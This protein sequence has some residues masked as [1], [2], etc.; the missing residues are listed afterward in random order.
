MA[1]KLFLSFLF[2]INITNILY[3]MGKKNQTSLSNIKKIELIDK[4]YRTIAVLPFANSIKSDD[5]AYIGR[6]IQKFLSSYLYSMDTI[7]I[8]TNDF[9][10]PEKYKTN[11]SI[12]YS[13]GSNFNRKAI[14]LNPDTVYKKYLKSKDPEDLSTF[15]REI[16]ADYI[17]SGSYRPHKKSPNHFSVF[18]SIFNTAQNKQVFNKNRIFNHAKL[19]ES[20]LRISIDIKKYFIPF[21]TGYMRIIT[22]ISNY[23]LFINHH[24]V[25]NK[26]TL[27]NLNTGEHAIEFRP[28]D[29]YPFKTNI[30][31]IS[32]QTNE[33]VLNT[34]KYFKKDAFL[35]VNSIPT[36]ASVFLNV[37]NIGYTPLLYT[38]LEKGKYRLKI[39][40]SNYTTLFKNIELNKGT[41]KFF[42][43]L[44]KRKPKQ[45]YKNR[46][47]KN[48][49]I[50]YSALGGGALCLLN[51]YFF[52]SA[53]KL[54]EDKFNYFYFIKYDY[55]K[56]KKH[57]EKEL[58]YRNISY[59]S[60][61]VGLGAMVISFVYFIKVINYDD[62][63][64]GYNFK[65]RINNDAS[66]DNK[67]LFYCQ[68]KF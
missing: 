28:L 66:T 63:N 15:S 54:E 40:K 47:K 41:N 33:L 10:I 29:Y 12:M 44:K 24:L 1:M 39:A 27:Y 8:T 4:D 31:V 67:Y 52:Y 20:I 18:F 65:K 46:N 42:F 14:I 30:T 32:N 9:V 19:E 51:A 45:F 23:E 53:A 50:M 25:R 64:I 56:S 55:K 16:Q 17:I 60:I 43:N 35:I 21:E 22:D 38:N 13:Y 11:T 37:K 59:T 58:L 48:K 62:I 6:T 5:Y 7:L 36:N 49:I 2:L 3:P 26:M 61:F 68:L 57:V 34:E